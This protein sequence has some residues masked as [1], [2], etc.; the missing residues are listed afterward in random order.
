MADSDNK[1]PLRRRIPVKSLIAIALII[2]IGLPIYS[3][4][5][6]RYYERYPGLGDRMENWRV[7]THARIPCSG[8]H[9][10]PGVAGLATFAVRAIPAFYSQLIQGPHPDN[11]LET[12]DREAC[13]KCHTSYRQVSANGDLLIPH[14]AHVEVL[15]V[16]CPTCHRDLVHT[17]NEAGYNSPRMSMCLEKCHDGKQAS[18]ECLDC[19]TR[20]H[21]PANHKSEDWLQVHSAKTDSEDCGSCHGWTPDFCDECHTKRPASHVGNWKKGHKDRVADRGEKGCA[22]CHDGRKFCKECHD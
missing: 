5:Q 20:K 8:C 14:R 12:P 22:V 16:N 17:A 15:E 11:L 1:R 2:L 6:P 18:N 4:L 3:T 21:V 10:D 7:S 19:H 13:Q 9:V